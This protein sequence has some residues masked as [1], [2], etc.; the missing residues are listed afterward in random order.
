MKAALC[1]CPEV[2]VVPRRFHQALWGVG[3]V[4]QKQVPNFVGCGIGEHRYPRM[5]QRHQ[6]LPEFNQPGLNLSRVRSSENNL[7]LS[8]GRGR[9]ANVQ[10][11]SADCYRE[12][13]GHHGIRA[14]E[15]V[16]RVHL[17]GRQNG[18]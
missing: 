12:S 17:A 2:L 15:G 14:L 4:T 1:H 13:R 9:N 7:Q 6:D 16:V 11:A 3:L 8:D 5:V 18:T 10:Q